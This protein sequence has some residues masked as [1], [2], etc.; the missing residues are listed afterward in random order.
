SQWSEWYN[1]SGRI[2][3][4][5]NVFIQYQ[6]WLETTDIMSLPTLFLVIIELN[7]PDLIIKGT[8][9]EDFGWSVSSAGDLD[10]N[11]FDDVI[12]GAPQN[13]SGQGSAYIFNGEY[14]TSES[15]DDGEIDLTQGDSATVTLAGESVSDL[16]GYSVSCAGRFSVDS[17]DDV[18]VGAPYAQLKGNIYYFYGNV[19]MNPNILASDADYMMMGENDFDY[20]GFSVSCANNVDNDT[21]GYI[22]TIIGSP[23]FDDVAKSDS[24]KVYVVH[25]HHQPD[26]WINGNV[27]DVYEIIPSGIQKNITYISSG[28]NATW[29][30]ALQNDGNMMDTF[31]FRI[32]SNIAG[33]WSWELRDN[34]TWSKISH[35][36][37]ILL[38]PFEMKNYTLN[39]SSPDFAIGGEEGWVLVS[40]I[41][42]NNTAQKDAINAS[43]R[44]EAEPPKI[45]APPIGPPTTGESIR[46]DAI[47]TDN[48]AVK[49]VHLLYWY[50]LADGGIDGP[51]NVTMD[52]EY[53]KNINVPDNA[54]KLYYVIS[55]NDTSFNWNETIEFTKD[56]EDNDLPEIVD[57]VVGSPTT[58]DAFTIIADV[59]D[60]IEID[61]VRLIYW[62]DLDKGGMEGPYNI[63]MNS[64]GNGKYE[65]PINITSNATLLNY[66]IYASDTSF[67]L[68]KSGEKNI[69]VQD[70][71]LPIITNAS[72]DP[73]SQNIG[74]QVNVTV[75]IEDNFGIQ[76]VWII[77]TY[78][79]D[80]QVNV[81][82]EMGSGNEWFHTDTYNE[83]G[84]YNFTIWVNDTNDNFNSSSLNQFEITTPPP[85][86]DYIQIRSE[87]DNNGKVLVLETSYLGSTDTFYASAYNH[88][89]G[90]IGEVEVDWISNNASRGIVNPSRGSRTILTAVGLGR[91]TILA[92]YDIGQNIQSSSTFDIEI[93]QEPVIVGTIPDIE[94]EEDFIL[95]SIDLSNYASDPQ[96]LVSELKWYL[97][98]FDD[99][100]LIAYSENSTGN[101]VISLISKDDKYGNMEVTYWLEDPHGNLDFQKAWINVT[102]VNDDPKIANCPDINVHFDTPY[103]FDYGYYI[104]DIDN[105]PSELTLASD[106]PS[107]TTINGFKVTYNYPE[108]MLG[109]ED[110]VTLTVS[111][112]EGNDSEL[113]RVKI[114]SNHPPV[115][116]A[117]IPDVTL[118]EN[119]T[120]LAVFDLDLHFI[121]SDGD[122]LEMSHGYS[123]VDITINSN[124]TVDLSASGEWSGTERVT[125]RAEDPI[126]GI[127]EQ[128][129]NITV[130]PVNDPPQ[131]KPL[132]PL[133]I[134][135]NYTYKFDLGWYISDKDNDIEDLVIFTSNPDNVTVEGTH[136]FLLYP[137]YWEGQRY[138]Y[139]VSLTVYVSDGLNTTFQATTVT[140]DENYPPEILIT[141]PDI[142]IFEDQE[143]I[144]AYDLD[145]HFIDFD[146]DPIYYTY[147]NDSIKVIIHD[148]NTID[149]IPPPN[150]FGSESITIRATD[151]KEAYY[152]DTL[153]VTVLSVNDPPLI[154]GIPIQVGEKDQDWILDLTE[155]ISDIDSE[156]VNLS[157]SVNST[158]VDIVGHFVIF[159]YPGNI[160]EDVI[161]IT[162]SDGENETTLPV[163]IQIL[164]PSSVLKGET[165][166]V[167][168][169]PF[170]LIAILISFLLAWKG[171]YAIE[172]IFL[173]TKSGLLIEHAGVKMSYE[174]G[175]EKDED[176]LAGMFVA[177]QEFIR[178]SFGGEEG[179]HLKRMDYGDKMVY[180]YRGNFVILAAFMQGR[181]PKPYYRKMKD[182]VEDIE[183]RYKGELEN[184]TGTIDAFPDIKAMLN[185][186]LEGRFIMEYRKLQNKSNEKKNT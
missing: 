172:D 29:W 35:G 130:I 54:T 136:L 95:H 175:G 112:G 26:L 144:G 90:Y 182:F 60:N 179:E 178:D 21:S 33:A 30:I 77:I 145:E 9:G 106:E 10:L 146:G 154:A 36:N 116:I 147:G 125:F 6:A 158:Y 150:W 32:T 11:G 114:T 140:V 42:Q 159:R 14:I 186:L 96:D 117:R 85:T 49:E 177:V 44:V 103:T 115:L 5:E 171:V 105:L 18:I 65:L 120:K 104:H 163:E 153:I 2:T 129:I 22:E 20:F 79:D 119:Q 50:D 173:I 92:I 74:G 25:L 19:S 63:T 137:E 165:W 73:L 155:Y 99:S 107:Y 111:D 3:S 109:S 12:I 84:I 56:V 83:A 72:A 126:G 157:V 88:S 78:P 183:E 121:D 15:A 89:E 180:I 149:F 24:G 75:E 128:T 91:V 41:S 43:A 113:I 39:I 1:N 52:P 45:L 151:D 135:Y 46:I 156:L 167:Y 51:D 160:S 110:Y 80:S 100:I 61:E 132:D 81:N 34:E 181:L 76:E 138:P 16:F 166:M 53:F 124:H 170:V 87:P 48:F 37:M 62:L 134:R 174:K 102:P 123:Q 176:I 133:K 97:T 98:D 57:D 69:L 101:Q 127:A 64:V 82:M 55:A 86:V 58:G 118:Y 152:E 141:L 122:R 59:T 184:W 27:D 131:I 108:S 94:I 66:E 67:N 31:E 8:P 169:L 143:I 4:P 38:D 185:S 40:V 162:V 70:D 168:I 47:A 164:P 23:Y 28:M 148:D 17:Y 93:S 161:W 7:L 68:N 71:D 142:L 13:N 139:T